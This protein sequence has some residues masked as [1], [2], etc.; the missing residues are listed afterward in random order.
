MDTTGRL[1]ILHIEDDM[2]QA[3]LIRRTL[4]RSGL[5]CHV[6]L[7]L[8]RDE[9]LDALQEGG[10]DLVLSDSR[11]FDFDGL[12]VLRVVRRYHPELPFFFLSGSFEGKD[13]TA[14]KAEGAAECL[15]KSDLTA[16]VPAI[17]RA[18]GRETR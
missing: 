3:E 5:A 2:M 1:H 11:G 12:E 15:L 7:A 10:V 9:Y 14:L 6:T 13:V 16:L 8:S 17:R 4:E 18:L